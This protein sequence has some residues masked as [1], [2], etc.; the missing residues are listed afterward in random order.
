MRNHP[1]MLIVSRNIFLDV[2][3]GR[4]GD[5]NLGAYYFVGGVGHRLAPGHRWS[6]D[7]IIAARQR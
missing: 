4:S 7:D 5:C 3:D 1:E 2:Q 6:V